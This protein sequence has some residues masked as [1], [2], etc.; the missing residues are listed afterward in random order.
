MSD[1]KCARCGEAM[2]AGAAFCGSCGAARGLPVMIE[3]ALDAETLRHFEVGARGLVRLRVQNRGAALDAVTVALTVDGRAIE[4]SRL[5]PFTAASE[6]V[7]TAFVA[8]ETAGFHELAGTLHAVAPDGAA[9]TFRVSPVHLRVGSERGP[10]S[11]TIDQ[12]N[13]RVVDN[14][15]SNFGIGATG[16]LVGDADWQP[17]T[18]V[19][20]TVTAA[21][22]APPPRPAARPV[23]FAVTT[24]RAT[25][26]LRETLGDGDIATVFGGHIRGNTLAQ[27]IALKLVNDRGDND[28][29]QHEV[30]VLAAL[31]VGERTD[32][33]GPTQH[34]PTVIDSLK[35][36]DGRLGTVFERCDGIDLVELRRRLPDGV[37]AR[38]LVWIM[39]RAF[40][41]LG[42][43]HAHGVLHGN[44]DPAHIIIR[45]RDHM[46]WIVDWSWAVV[47]PARTGQGFKAL[48]E[49]YSPPEV[50]ERKPPIPA[51]DLYAL[52][53]CMFFAAGGDPVAKRLPE[54]DERLARFL[55][56]LVV[57][58]P[59]GR[60]QD[61]VEMYLQIDRVRAQIWG[62]HEFVTLDVPGM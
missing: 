61:A 59:L 51:S 48:N 7:A 43:A 47:N 30:D 11:I 1:V 18:L 12:S 3:A 34:L 6:A 52:G 13:A 62:A 42:L 5:G 24:A 54:M 9:V 32:R 46:L 10:V 56:Y 25:Y 40:A 31:R 35:T 60:P 53:K 58:S 36:A 37:P 57:E 14:S 38:H 50:G 39:R 2:R 22:S 26:E 41:A 4:P 17:L 49:T 20:E 15:R 44:L 28:L 45:P 33:P 21:P 23:S 27:P 8:P 55:K 29:I 19:A 16:G